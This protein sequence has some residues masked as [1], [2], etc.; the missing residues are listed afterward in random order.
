M[1]DQQLRVCARYVGP[2]C[3]GLERARAYI[4][5]IQIRYLGAGCVFADIQP[6]FNDLTLWTIVT[7]REV[8]THC[9]AKLSPSIKKVPVRSHCS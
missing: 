4:L 7:L 6:F 3:L 8:P 2:R 5:G 1:G 9:Q